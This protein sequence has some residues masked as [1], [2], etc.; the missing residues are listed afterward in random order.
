MTRKSEKVNTEELRAALEDVGTLMRLPPKR[1]SAETPVKAQP[2]VE[3]NPSGAGPSIK[4][5]ALPIIA[6]VFVAIA[7]LVYF[8]P[9][10]PVAVPADLQREWFSRHANYA[11]RRIQF[12]DDTLYMTVDPAKPPQPY[13]ITAVKQIQKGDSTLLVVS[14]D[15]AGGIIELQAA[16]HMQPAPRLVFARPEGLVWEP[17]A[18][19]KP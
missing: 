13:R 12:T 6:V 15:D 19:A 1:P 14:Y 8:W 3:R 16:L 11:G 9:S 4:L 7:G 5:T 10:A 18:G 2:A 17:T